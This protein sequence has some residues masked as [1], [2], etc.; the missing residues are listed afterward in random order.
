MLTL[1]PNSFVETGGPCDSGIRRI[2]GQPS[3]ENDNGVLMTEIQDKYIP[4]FALPYRNIQRYIK[5]VG[6]DWDRLDEDQRMSVKKS[7]KNMDLCNNM[8]AGKREGFSNESP[9]G[10]ISCA[11]QY[12]SQSPDNINKILD[13]IWKPTGA[14]QKMYNINPE[15]KYAYKKSIDKWSVENTLALHCN[16]FSGIAFFISIVFFLIIGIVIGKMGK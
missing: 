16:V 3:R 10:S 8:K 13:I 11:M 1:A 12:I 7:F 6:N 2:R 14:Q 4:E 15:T 9:D 5:E